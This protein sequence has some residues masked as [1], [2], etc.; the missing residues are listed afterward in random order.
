MSV[1]IILLETKKITK[2]RKMRTQTFDQEACE[3]YHAFLSGLN[4]ADSVIKHQESIVYNVD[5]QTKKKMSEIT[6][7]HMRRLGV[8]F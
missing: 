2:I 4:D 6:D 8:I 7:Y 1:D 3:A 5:Y